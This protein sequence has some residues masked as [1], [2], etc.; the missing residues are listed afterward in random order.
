M[1]SDA[2]T[3]SV[4]VLPVTVFAKICIPPP[5]RCARTSAGKYLSQNGYGWLLLFLLMLLLLLPLLFLLLMH[6]PIACGNLVLCFIF[7]PISPLMTFF[8]HH[9]LSSTG[10]LQLIIAQGELIT[11]LGV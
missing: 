4:I 9:L 5:K 6:P 11:A 10:R 7:C 2:S 8:A 1:M 3:L